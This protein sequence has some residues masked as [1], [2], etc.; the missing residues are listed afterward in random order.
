MPKKKEQTKEGIKI[1]IYIAATIGALGA[2][3]PAYATFV[4]PNWIEV[5]HTTLELPRLD[6]Q[7]DGYKL[8]QISDIHAGEWLPLS[9]LHRIVAM[10]NETQ[11]DLIAITGDFVTRVYARAPIG[12]GPALRELRAKDGVAAILG[13][14]DYWGKLGPG[15]IR[16]LIWDNGLIDLNNKVHTIRRDGAQ[17]NIAGVDSA[18]EGKDRLRMVLDKLPQEGATIL[19]AHEPDFANT[20]STKQRFD[21]Q[22]SGHSHGGQ[23][24]F[25]ILGMLRLPPL[26]RKYPKGLYKV[27]DMYLYTNRGLGVVGVPFR[28]MSRPEIAV[29]TLKAGQ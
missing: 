5:T 12:I 16:R 8:V 2:A 23:V 21:L 17:L 9:R 19:L 7:F 4:E 1:G 24:A 11:P 15:L 20:A 10:V 14:H 27:G 18:R 3:L 13:N 28:F 26:G 6:P 22:L 25:P 29:F